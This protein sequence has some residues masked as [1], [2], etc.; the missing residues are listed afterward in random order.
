[1]LQQQNCTTASLDLNAVGDADNIYIL[2]LSSNL[3]LSLFSTAGTE[4]SI[5]ENRSGYLSSKTPIQAN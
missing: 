5:L 3:L 1:M 4:A 2:I